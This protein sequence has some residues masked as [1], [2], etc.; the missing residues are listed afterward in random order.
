MESAVR[1]FAVDDVLAFRRFIV[2][3]FRPW[4]D[5][6]TTQRDLVSFEDLAVTEQRQRSRV[7]HDHH[8]VGF[9][10]RTVV[11]CPARRA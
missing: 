6:V 11:R 5:R 2:T 10:C 4:A 3:S 9:R 8:A 1:L 7:L